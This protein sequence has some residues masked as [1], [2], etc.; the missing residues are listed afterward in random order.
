ML[1]DNHKLSGPQCCIKLVPEGGD[2]A[3]ASVR[4]KIDNELRAKVE[5]RVNV[6][7]DETPLCRVCKTFA[8]SQ[9]WNVHHIPALSHLPGT[10]EG[11]VYHLRSW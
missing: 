1:G 4:L 8:T 3:P 5:A 10:P 2:T 7:P 9:R 11:I 6:E